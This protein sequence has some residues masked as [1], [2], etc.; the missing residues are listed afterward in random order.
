[1]QVLAPERWTI[2]RLPAPSR[3]GGDS[4]QPR[5]VQVGRQTVTISPTDAF[6]S[7]D[8]IR[9][10]GDGS[11]L[12]DRSH[13]G[14]SWSSQS[15]IWFKGKETP[16][17]N[18][19]VAIY[20]DRLNYAGTVVTDEAATGMPMSPP[21]GFVVEKGKRRSLGYGDVN[22]WSSDGTFV[23]T[24]PVNADGNPASPEDTE[25][26]VVRVIS[27][28]HSMAFPGFEF[29]GQDADGA[30]VMEAGSRILRYRAGKIL[31]HY[32]LP[33]RWAVARMSPAGWLLLRR[34]SARKRDPMPDLPKD[35]EK[36]KEW[37][38]RMSAWQD[39]D[40]AAMTETERDWTAAVAIGGKMVPLQ[41]VRP[42]KTEHLLWRNEY[43]ILGKDALRFDAFLGD[44]WQTFRLA[45]P[46]KSLVRR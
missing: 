42:P 26:F 17:R 37:S 4:H 44:E 25:S 31:G 15:S 46:A 39:D 29:V 30:V 12:I 8:R 18:G 23:L 1:M 19:S 20:R 38:D 22:A 33:D 10:G 16:V 3:E 2:Q 32:K 27:P 7:L 24:A 14:I 36:M 28:G 41:F 13:H 21:E 5:K 35:P 9:K 11:L 43:G 40:L 34:E 6:E 45:A